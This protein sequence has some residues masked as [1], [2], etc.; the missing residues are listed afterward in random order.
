DGLPGSARL[1]GAIDAE[2]L[3]ARRAQAARDL[4]A[5]AESLRFLAG[6]DVHSPQDLRALEAHGRTAWE[7]R[8]LVLGRGA[9]ALRARAEEQG[10]AG[11]LDLALLWADLKRRLARQ[12]GTGD[13]R[14]EV[15]AT[16]AEAESLLGSCPALARE[17]RLL[18][19]A[20][21][22]ETPSAPVRR[23]WWE[24]LTL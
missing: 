16:L 6:A 23:T 15:E 17:R 3:Q 18:A 14:A 20:A 19:G 5:V 7:A 1:L 24:H 11:L 8:G 13:G 2:L 12:G 4:H 10:R 22:D 21:G 9:A